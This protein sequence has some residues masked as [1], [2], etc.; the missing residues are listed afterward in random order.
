MKLHFKNPVYFT[1]AK[2]LDGLFLL[3]TDEGKQAIMDTWKYYV[4]K[5]QVIIYGYVIMSN[6]YHIIWQFDDEKFFWEYQRDAHKFMAKSIIGSLKNEKNSYLLN[7]I[8]VNAA[9]R[10]YQVWERDALSKEV[11]TEPFFMQKLNYTHNN[12]CRTNPPLAINAEDYLWS[13]ANFYL[14]GIDPFGILTHIY[15]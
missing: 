11:L 10:K 3:Y 15:E 12:P 9:D 14:N 1:T 6:H 5:Q 2:C 8:E 7:Q 13:S 4:D